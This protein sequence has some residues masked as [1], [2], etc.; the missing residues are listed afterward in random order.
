MAANAQATLKQLVD[1]CGLSCI[2]E[3]D[4]MA[5]VEACKEMLR[6]QAEAMVVNNADR[7]LLFSYSCDGTPIQFL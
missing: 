5:M 2:N 6:A 4:E 1:H 3:A 7:P